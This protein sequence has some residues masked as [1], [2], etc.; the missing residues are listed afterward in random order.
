MWRHRSGLALA[1]VMDNLP[2]GTGHYLNQCLL[3][4]KCVLWPLFE[5]DFTSS[6][7][8]SPNVFGDY[9]FT[10]ITTFCRTKSFNSLAPQRFRC[11]FRNAIINLVLLMGFIRSCYDNMLRWVPLDLVDDRSTLV[12]VT[13][14]SHYLI[15]CWLRFVLP[16]GVTR[17][18][19][20][21]CSWMQCRV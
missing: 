12:Q 19:E 6:N 18:N 15:K 3:V 8:L 4:V 7:T 11:D 14:P 2:D 21:I 17:S 9:I 13:A 1:Q 16:Y 10:I 20:L 5:S